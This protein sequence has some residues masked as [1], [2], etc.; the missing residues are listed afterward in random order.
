[1]RLF[2]ILAFLLTPLTAQAQ[3]SSRAILVMDGSG[4]MWGQIDGEAKITIAQ[5]VVRDLLV[6]LPGTLE[7]GLTIY[8]HRRKGDCS[9][10]ETVVMPGADTQAEIAAAVN[11]IK[12]KGKTPMTEAVR[13]AALALRYTE[14]KATVILVS[15]GIETCV[16][17]P[18]DAARAL[19]ETGVD[20]TAHVIGFGVTDT[21]AL[22]QMRC[23]ADETGGTFRTASNAGE[24]ADALQV[25]AAAPPEPPAP[26]RFDVTFNAKDGPGG[27]TI[28]RGLVWKVTTP[29]GKNIL[30]GGD[31]MTPTLTMLTGEYRAAVTR[32]RDGASAERSFTVDGYET[33]VLVLPELPPEPV[34]VTIFATDGKNGPR[35]S[36]PLIWDVTG[37]GKTVVDTG[38]SANLDLRLVAGEYVVSVMRPADESTAELRFG[39]GKVNKTLTLAL[40]EYRPAATLEAPDTAPMGSLVGVRWTG[41]DQANDF[42]S[43]AELDAGE[44]SWDEYT[45]TREG[46][47]LQLRMPAKPGTYQIRYVLNDGRKA[48]ARRTI[49]ITPVGAT[50][51]PPAELPAGDTVAIDWTGPDYQNDFV[52]VVQAGEDGNKWINYTY[53]REGS[54]MRL[55]MPPEEGDYEIVYVMQQDRTVI[56]RTPVRVA[57]VAFSVTAPATAAVGES[58]TVDWV[59]GG[60]QNDFIAVVEAGAD[61]GKWINYTY[62]REGSPLKL[63]MPLAPGAYEIRYILAQDRTT[64]ARVPIE[65]VAASATLDI[66]ASAPAGSELV[67]TWEGPAYRNDFISVAT[68]D[69][70]ARKYSGY[71]Y[72][73]DGSPLKLRMPTEP[74]DYEV[75]YVL[76]GSKP[77]LLA[78]V[79]IRVDPVSAALEAD[80][81]VAAGGNL[82]VTWEGPAYRND[83]I[84]IFPAGE[85]KRYLTYSYT[86]DGSPLIVK[87]PK[88]PGAYELRYVLGQDRKVLATVPLTVE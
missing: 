9:D 83:F 79:P 65:L 49:T 48:L 36:D 77:R 57:A 43:V 63:T 50:I 11:A 40:P 42:I 41:P 64:K 51:T 84:A 30:S 62:T 37:G 56:A 80:T 34:R 75:R 86:R 12:P 88:E 82:A 33:V 1:M 24:L 31:D 69:Q 73:R 61:E 45:Y 27:L 52:A 55:E 68:S 32:E 53:T 60:Y 22:R 47:L 87:A 78:T 26:K 16:P 54:P 76:A 81:S 28:T 23:L 72:T 17:D 70:E 59:G 19:E 44:G 4:S 2:L 13:Q 8:G 5:K 18:C 29:D 71:S 20:F 14:E 6:T 38:Q 66:A 21:E 25:V 15:D 67:V 58:V 7:L 74:G 10:I 39:V 46:P 35:I 3:D 85:D